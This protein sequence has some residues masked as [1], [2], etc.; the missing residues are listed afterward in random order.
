MFTNIL[1]FV[2]R[3]FF[4]IG[5]TDFPLYPVLVFVE[6]GIG[7]MI[8]NG[9]IIRVIL[10]H[11]CRIFIVT[12]ITICRGSISHIRSKLLAGD[13]AFFVERIKPIKFCIGD[14]LRTDIRTFAILYGN[15]DNRIVPAFHFIGCWSNVFVSNRAVV[16]VVFLENEI[17]WSNL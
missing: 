5:T 9:S 11:R 4:G 12:L 3:V 10:Y 1:W 14:C 8:G 17:A 2:F 6:L 15:I 16:V 7:I 13:T